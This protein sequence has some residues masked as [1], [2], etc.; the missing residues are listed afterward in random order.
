M[1]MPTR[2]LFAA[3]NSPHSSV[4]RVPFVWM[5]VEDLLARSL[6]LLDELDRASEEVEAHQGRFA[7]LPGDDDLRH[8][9]VRFEH[10]A[11]VGLLQLFGHPESAAR[12]QHLLGQEEAVVAIE[13][14]GRPGGLRHQMEGARG[15]RHG[16]DRASSLG[17]DVHL[18]EEPTDPSVVDIA[19]WRPWLPRPAAI[20]TSPVRVG[21][22]ISS[23]LAYLGAGRRRV[24]PAPDSTFGS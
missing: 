1:E 13:V 14:A 8:G 3:R 22:A 5:R 11:E 6:V 20:S 9:A 4:S 23:I 24:V 18:A 10:L 21:P 16:E 12:V 7:A 2:N 17:I 19:I 15:T